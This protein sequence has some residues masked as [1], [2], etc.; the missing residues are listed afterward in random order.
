MHGL[1]QTQRQSVHAFRTADA[2]KLYSDAEASSESRLMGCE[3]LGKVHPATASRRVVSIS[4]VWKGG[5]PGGFHLITHVGDRSADDHHSLRSGCKH[6]CDVNSVCISAHGGCVGNMRD[7]RSTARLPGDSKMSFL[8]P[9]AIP[10]PRSFP[11]KTPL[12]ALSVKCDRL[13]IPLA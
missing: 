11:P 8:I 12:V 7:H 10:I 3:T 4:R 5:G 2:T 1:C 9:E 6:H 13:T